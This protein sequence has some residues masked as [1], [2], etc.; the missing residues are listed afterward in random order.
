[1]LSDTVVYMPSVS[2]ARQYVRLWLVRCLVC[3]ALVSQVLTLGY[4]TYV[5][6]LLQV[7]C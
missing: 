4:Y 7:Q 6:C 5:K 2:V 1:M 3:Q